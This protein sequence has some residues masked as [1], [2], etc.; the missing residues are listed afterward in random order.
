MKPGVK[1]IQF[2][3][4]MFSIILEAEIRSQKSAKQYDFCSQLEEE[5]YWNESPI[6]PLP[7]S[8][9]ITPIHYLKR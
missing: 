3:K 5:I 6:H 7:L 2:G 1:E 4:S 9:T 8:F